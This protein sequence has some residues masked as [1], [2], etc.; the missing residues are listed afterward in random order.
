MGSVRRTSQRGSACGPLPLGWWQWKLDQL[1]S[2][3]SHRAPKRAQVESL[4]FIEIEK[5]ASEPFLLSSAM[6]G[7]SDFRSDLIERRSCAVELAGNRLITALRNGE[8]DAHGNMAA[9]GSR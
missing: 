5:I 2:K 7:A 1:R 3:K 6:A 4:A 8:N 9:G